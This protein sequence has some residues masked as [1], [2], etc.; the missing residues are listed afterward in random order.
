[1]EATLHNWLAKGHFSQS[2]FLDYFKLIIFHSKNVS[3]TS[4]VDWNQN[5]IGLEQFHL[6]YFCPML[7]KLGK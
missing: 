4:T 1:M 3:F 5:S 7:D 6:L 2:E